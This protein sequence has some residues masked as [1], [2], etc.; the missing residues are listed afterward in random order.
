[1]T[2]WLGSFR[3]R[4]ATRLSRLA[5][6]LC[7]AAA[8][9]IPLVAASGCARSLEFGSNGG[10]SVTR[11]P[12]RLKFTIETDSAHET[13]AQ[14]LS[15]QFQALGGKVS[16][17]VLPWSNVVSRALAG[18]SD[19]CLL[20]W[21]FPTPDPLPMVAVKL[22][23][24]GSLNLSG[25]ANPEVDRLLVASLRLP[26]EEERTAC[27]EAL[28][29]TVYEEAPWVF[30][31]TEI[32]FDAATT[33]LTGWT[34]GPGGAA[35][36][37]G[38]TLGSLGGRATVGLGLDARP[39]LDPF[40]P[41]D[42]RAACLLRCLFDALA[43]MGPDGS[44]VP[45]LAAGWEWSADARQL[46]VKLRSGVLFHNKKP[47]A[48]RDVVWTYTRAL[49]GRLPAGLA[50]SAVA[51]DAGTVI[52][53]FSAPF[54]TF[55]QL[56]GLLPIVP[57]DYYETVGP[58]GF[59][60]APVG[61]GPFR[62]NPS[63]P[64]RPFLLVRWEGY[65]GGPPALASPG[66]GGLAE[67]AF[68]FQPDP[69]KRRLALERGEIVLAPALTAEEARPFRSVAGA[70]VVAEPGR[71]LLALELNNRRRPFSDA[72][73]RQ[74]LNFAIDRQA[75][76]LT[77]GE[78]AAPLCGVFFPDSPGF[79]ASAGT[80]ELDLERAKALLAEAGYLTGQP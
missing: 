76:A 75:L 55:L 12:E 71:G 16:V 68:V 8:L 27:L 61:T 42:P 60:R 4:A 6:V 49:E 43:A 35:S 40:A 51:A 67:V 22:G 13:L 18:E 73:V 45:E 14:A 79:S 56:Y 17:R 62:Y 39:P 32:L 57:A 29:E 20:D 52:F 7:A 31:A 44:L 59:A 2:G 5:T 47:L 24:G 77:A 38:A 69:A 37:R 58:E 80:Y 48:A 34:P 64:D 11:R 63:L 66:S 21:Y 46:T 26:E 10:P 33:S 53:T 65:Y 41:A 78:E 36:L 74:A 15:S 19:A 3:R 28:Q 1:M 70:R 72:R 54:P 30:G 25:Y 23:Q 50:V 9:L